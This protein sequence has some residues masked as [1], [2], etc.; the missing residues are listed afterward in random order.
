MTYVS[1]DWHGCSPKKIKALLEL[2][3]FGENDFL[4]VI[5]D[6]I[7]RGEHSAEL[8][9]YLMLAPNIE[10]ILGNHEAFLLAN[11][12]IFDEVTE[13]SLDKIDVKKL[14]TLQDWKDNGADATIAALRRESPETRAEILEY[15][16][17]C[18]LC[19]VACVGDTDFLLVHGGLGN[20]RPDKKLS[21]Y[22]SAE[23]L[24]E[25]PALDTRYDLG[26]NVK[27]IVGHTPT[28]YYGSFYKGKILHF[29]DS[30]INI[31]TGA[32]S[33]LSPCLLRLDDMKEFYLD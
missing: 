3:D 12:W 33:G 16:R 32:A 15:L 5:G 24:W 13:E 28:H 27:V 1:S 23:L 7:D 31:D 20:F 10:L 4:F 17:D 26:E 14:A 9:K 2:A 19:D 18:P 11:D 21:E 29:N 25:R 22:T 30:L 8:L 6:V